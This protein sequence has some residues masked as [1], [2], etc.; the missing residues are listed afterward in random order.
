VVVTKEEANIAKIK[1][2]IDWESV[3][4]RLKEYRNISNNYL[5]ETLKAKS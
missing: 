5:L 3:N 4:S 1:Q 2:K